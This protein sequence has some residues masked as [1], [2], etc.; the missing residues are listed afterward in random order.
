[1]ARFGLV[2]AVAIMLSACASDTSQSSG[3]DLGE[4]GAR[5]AFVAGPDA[6]ASAL[7]SDT[8]IADADGARCAADR[9]AGQLDANQMRHIRQQATLGGLSLST[10]EAGKLVDALFDCTDPR[11]GLIVGL[12]ASGLDATT[13]ACIGSSI[14]PQV[15]AT[16]MAHSFSDGNA[17]GLTPLAAAFD[18]ATVLCR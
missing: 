9:I 17:E 7:I 13:A 18:R 8:L 1:M 10:A 14:D 3:S 4:P 5:L 12:H 16:A 15:Y 2:L 6:V 11:D